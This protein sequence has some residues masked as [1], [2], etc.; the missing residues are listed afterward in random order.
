MRKTLLILALAFFSWA[1]DGMWSNY[2]QG[3]QKAAATGAGMFVIVGSKTCPFCKKLK[4][5][6]EESPYLRKKMGIFIPVYVDK[7]SDFI[8]VDLLEKSEN[9]P[10]VF[11][12]AKNNEIIGGPI[13]GYR[14]SSE[15]ARIIDAMKSEFFEKSKAH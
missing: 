2:V 8:P 6:I 14:T 13:Y 10:A 3:F 4:K 12:V 11:V 1:S 7:E 15:M 9:V 5:E